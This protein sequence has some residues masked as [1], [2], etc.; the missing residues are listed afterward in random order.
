MGDEPLM[1]IMLSTAV[2]LDADPD[3]AMEVRYVEPG[4]QWSG[5]HVGAWV[6]NSILLTAGHWHPERS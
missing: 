6:W 4:R 5:F 1:V 3:G 2:F